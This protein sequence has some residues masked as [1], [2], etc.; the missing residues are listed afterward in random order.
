MRF[1]DANVFIYA[2]YKPKK[3]LTERQKELKEQAKGI[4]TRINEGEKVITTVIHL[5]EVSNILKRA[6]RLEE[7]NSLLV[8]LYSLDNVTI[9]DVAAEDYLG[10]IEL[11]RDL[12]RDPNDCLA[13]EVMKR[14][15]VHEI[16]TFDSGFDSLTEKLP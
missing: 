16:Y 15:G 8:G 2:Y 11:V 9:L 7:L 10:A 5:S 4:I 3:E 6:L 14:E 1:L 13:V 12:K